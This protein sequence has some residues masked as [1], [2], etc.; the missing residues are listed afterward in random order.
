MTAR[1]LAVQSHLVIHRTSRAWRGFVHLT[2][3]LA[4]WFRGA[5]PLLLGGAALGALLGLAV[6]LAQPRL[7]AAK[8]VVS[9]EP[10][11]F[12]QNT[13]LSMRGLI[14]NYALQLR[15]EA[16]IE[17]ALRAADRSESAGRV[18]ALTTVTGN[19]DELTLVVRVLAPR[20]TDAV[21]LVQALLS[22]FQREIE[23][24][25][26]RQARENRLRVLVLEPAWSAVP[27]S[28]DYCAAIF[29]GAGAGLLVGLAVGLVRSWH[30]RTTFS[31]P[32]EVE[33]FLD[34]PILG[35]IPPGK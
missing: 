34:A 23:A 25:N 21:A 18:R 12:G 5:A 30:R 11:V 8:S 20:P 4:R 31:R 16:L 32:L 15:S 35:T 13:V 24:A 22:Q 14:Y 9:L 28:P 26:R 29:P 10:E 7:F 3:T 33:R 17:R 27:A 19:P 6:T 1:R 2:L